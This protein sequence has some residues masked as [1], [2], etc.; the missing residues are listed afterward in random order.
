MLRFKKL[1]KGL[2]LS[3]LIIL[4]GIYILNSTDSILEKVIGIAN[5]GFFG[6]LIIWGIFKLVKNSQ[7]NSN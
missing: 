3:I 2:G 4:L 1:L 5:I 7:S 6:I